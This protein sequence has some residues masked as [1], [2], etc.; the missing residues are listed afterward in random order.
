MQKVIKVLREDLTSHDGEQWKLH[1]THK[2]SSFESSFHVYR[3][4]ELASFQ[5]N[6]QEVPGYKRPPLTRAFIGEAPRSV[7]S[8]PI[9]LWVSE[10]VLT[11][12]IPFPKPTQKQTV[13]FALL[14]VAAVRQ[15]NTPEWE[16][17][18]A[19]LISGNPMQKHKELR[20]SEIAG[21]AST[22]TEAQTP[23]LAAWCCWAAPTT[24][25]HELP[26]TYLIAADNNYG[27]QL[28]SQLSQAIWAAQ[29]AAPAAYLEKGK[30]VDFDALAKQALTYGHL[31]EL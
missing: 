24:P 22:T 12:E 21:G 6:Y 26:H 25:P 15:D 30:N 23:S 2:S 20:I 29:T 27:T 19:D 7:A 28:A 31:L 3:S 13:L 16:A 11:Q 18:Y 17:W 1:E 10:L 9:E 8:T 14:C 5:A 4:V